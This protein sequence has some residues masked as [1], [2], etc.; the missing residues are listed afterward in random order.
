MTEKRFDTQKELLTKTKEQL[1]D[2]VDSVMMFED[3]LTVL[4]EDLNKVKRM[5][6]EN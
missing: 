5:V 6:D 2:R 3:K 1:E 4:S